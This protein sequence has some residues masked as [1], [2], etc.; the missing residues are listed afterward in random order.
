SLTERWKEHRHHQRSGLPCHC[1]SRTG[2]G[3]SG[4]K[5]WRG[6]APTSGTEL[7]T[8]C[9]DGQRTE[10]TKLSFQRLPSH[11]Q[12]RTSQGYS[13]T[14]TRVI[15]KAMHGDLHRDSLPEQPVVR[16]TGEKLQAFHPTYNRGRPH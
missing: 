3:C 12:S 7:H 2:V 14:G 8:P 4:T 9:I 6:G 16:I 11:R 5:T 10:W 13:R 15:E 1:R